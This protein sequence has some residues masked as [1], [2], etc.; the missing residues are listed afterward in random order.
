MSLSLKGAAL[1]LAAAAMTG[2]GGETGVA[3]GPTPATT[4]VAVNSSNPTVQGVTAP[5]TST[6]AA[7]PAAATPP[8]ATPQVATAPAPAAPSPTTGT[9]TLDWVPPTQTTDGGVLTDLAGYYVYYGTDANHLNQRVQLRN[10]G[11]TAYVIDG[12]PQ[13]S[14]VFAVSAYNSAG[15]ESTLSN[16]AS[17]TVL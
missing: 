11:L 10:P 13:G 9:A 17:K 6:D 15:I 5:R 4:P 3:G 7:T 16:I 1:L 14:Y 8:V 12:L 2:C